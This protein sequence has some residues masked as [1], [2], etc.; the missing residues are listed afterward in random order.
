[1]TFPY[2]PAQTAVGQGAAV[3]TTQFVGAFYQKPV[4]RPVNNPFKKFVKDVPNAILHPYFPIPI[5]SPKAVPYDGRWYFG[6][7]GSVY[8]TCTR[9]ARVIG[10]HC[11]VIGTGAEANFSGWST[12]PQGLATTIGN[13]LPLNA[14]YLL[15]G[16]YSGV[17]K[18]AAGTP[19]LAAI[20][21]LLPCRDQIYGAAGAVTANVNSIAITSSGTLKPA[22]PYDP[23]VTLASGAAGW[24]NAHE[25]VDFANPQSFIAPINNLNKRPDFAGNEMLLGM[26]ATLHLQCAPGIAYNQK[27]IH[28]LFEQL[29]LSGIVGKIEYPITGGGNQVAFGTSKNPTFGRMLVEPVVGMR[30]DM[31]ALAVENAIPE[32]EWCIPFLYPYGSSNGSY[33]IMDQPGMTAAEMKTVPHIFVQEF[34]PGSPMWAGVM[35]PHKAGTIGVSMIINEGLCWVSGFSYEFLFSG[36]AS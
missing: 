20:P 6:D 16:A 9:G 23:S 11:S 31:I 14:A 26:D 25:N 7:G 29:P 33:G 2:T 36:S 13:F 17:P 35:P 10:A 12:R 5:D 22:N 15:N 21:G 24:Y 3:A 19:V 34:G 4:I 28:T 1:M 18:N 27:L 30:E 8:V 32:A